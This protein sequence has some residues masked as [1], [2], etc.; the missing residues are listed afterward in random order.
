MISTSGKA[1]RFFSKERSPVL[2]TFLGKVTV[3]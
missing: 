3:P 1:S 2:N